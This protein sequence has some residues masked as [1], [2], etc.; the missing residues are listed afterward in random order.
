MGAFFM[1]DTAT[2]YQDKY[3][4]QAAAL[5]LCGFSMHLADGTG[6][7]ID[8]TQEQLAQILRLVDMP[9]KLVGDGGLIAFSNYLITSAELAA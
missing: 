4:K 1:G 9:D 8:V 6:S 5:S 2:K 7:L 3:A